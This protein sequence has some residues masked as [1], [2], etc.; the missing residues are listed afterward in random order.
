MM[1]V[2]V[3]VDLPAGIR[4]VD[5][6]ESVEQQLHLHVADAGNPFRVQKRGT[7]RGSMRAVCAKRQATSLGILGNVCR[8]RVR[9][10]RE[11]RGRWVRAIIRRD[12]ERVWARI[13]HVVGSEDVKNSA[14]SRLVVAALRVGSERRAPAAR[15][16]IMSVAIGGSAG[17]G[18]LVLV[19]TVLASDASMALRE[20]LERRREKSVA[21]APELFVACEPA[22]AL[23]AK[24]FVVVDVI[25]QDALGP[26]RPPVRVEERQRHRLHAEIPPV[27]HSTALELLRRAKGRVHVERIHE[28]SA[29]HV[30]CDDSPAAPIVAVVLAH[31]NVVWLLRADTQGGENGGS[32]SRMRRE[33]RAIIAIAEELGGSSGGVGMK[34]GGMYRCVVIVAGVVVIVA[35]VVVIVAGLVVVSTVSGKRGFRDGCARPGA[36]TSTDFVV[37][38]RLRD[39]RGRATGIRLTRAIVRP[40]RPVVKRLKVVAVDG[41]VQPTARTVC[42]ARRGAIAAKDGQFVRMHAPLVFGSVAR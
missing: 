39:S 2:A 38:V 30:E 26:E 15:A 36:P 31:L 23:A 33:E 19:K 40:A 5:A 3:Q 32:A 28:S 14:V 42:I 8:A 1:Y 25:E 27:V 9:G 37:A 24:L 35:G 22:V 41:I 29:V 17:A 21:H 34:G 12:G 16:Q 10:V 13:D 6:V 20:L 4:R 7:H 18:N 11:E